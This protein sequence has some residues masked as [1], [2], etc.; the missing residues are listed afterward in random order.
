MWF[1][2]LTVA[3][4]HIQYTFLSLCRFCFTRKQTKHENTR[5]PPFSYHTKMAAN[6]STSA[7]SINT[8]RAPLIIMTRVIAH[9]IVFTELCRKFIPTRTSVNTLIKGTFQQGCY[10]TGDKALSRSQ[11][12]TQTVYYSGRRLRVLKCCCFF[13]S[14]R[15][16]DCFAAS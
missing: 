4:C 14:R 12:N 2:L 6:V 10:Q 1:I 9:V 16:F 11:H 7:Q 13:F 15:T 5:S 8:E 3:T